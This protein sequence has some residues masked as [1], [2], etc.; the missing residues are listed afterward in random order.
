MINRDTTTTTRKCFSSFF[1][2]TF[3]YWLQIPIDMSKN[4][5]SSKF[6]CIFSIFSFWINN[7]IIEFVL[8]SKLVLA[9]WTKYSMMIIAYACIERRKL[10]FTVYIYPKK[11]KKTRRERKRRR[12]NEWTFDKARERVFFADKQIRRRKEKLLTRRKGEECHHHRLL[13]QT[14]T[15]T[16]T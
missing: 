5:F 7:W 3:F 13:S 6:D 12:M 9:R 14:H 4:F 2:F 11:K 8:R 15:H 16:H 1:C 10:W